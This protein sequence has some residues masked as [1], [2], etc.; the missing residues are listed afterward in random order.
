MVFNIFLK[1][2][3]IISLVTALELLILFTFHP[4]NSYMEDFMNYLMTFLEG[5]ASFISPCILPLIPLYI[6]YFSGSEKDNTKKTLLNAIIF[7]LGFTLIFI[8]M[9][10]FASSLGVA[11]NQHIKIIKLIFGIICIIFGLLYMDIFKF[12]VLGK[13]FNFKFD[14][15]NLNII[16]SFVFGIFF[17][18]SHAPCTGMFLGAALMLITKEQNILQGILLMLTYS[19]GIG[20]PFIISALLIQ[21][22]KTVFDFIKKHFKAVK[23]IAGIL[24]IITGIYLIVF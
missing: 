2:Y 6:S 13:S 15:S 1:F 10:V 4:T 11:I 23:I 3:D 20:I 24:L 12:K 16:R 7:C 9:A 22:L 17:S 8:L 14:V 21:K 5:F 18:V 19:L